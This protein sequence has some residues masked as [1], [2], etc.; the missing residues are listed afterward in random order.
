MRPLAASIEELE[1]LSAQLGD[2]LDG[3]EGDPAALMELENRIARWDSLKRKYGAD[4]ETVANQLAEF[5]RKLAAIEQRD[6]MLAQLEAAEQ[7][8]LAGLMKQGKALSK[9]RKAAQPKLEA[10]FLGHAQQLGFLQAHFAVELQE[11]ASPSPSGLEEAEFLF[12]PN[13][14]EP[15]KPLRMIASSGELARVM[16]A[17]KSALAKQDDTPLLV[18]DEIDA[19]VGGE[20]ARAVGRKMC[21]LGQDHQVI[22]ITHFPQVA[23]LADHHYL[24]TKVQEGGRSLS[25]LNEV[26]GEPRVKELVRMLGTDG[27]SAYAHARDLLKN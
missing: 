23:A 6:D 16:L 21:E 5:K 22:A 11:L 24:I 15:L 26:Q 18:F 20:I 9:A 2:Y 8:A 3:M 17:L 7:K 4:F 27:E 19:N 10:S 14:G 25:R 1:E 12:G 13:P